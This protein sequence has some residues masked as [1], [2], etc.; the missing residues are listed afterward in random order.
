MSGGDFRNVHTIDDRCDSASIHGRH[1][2]R[3]ALEAEEENPDFAVL[4]ERGYLPEGR[5]ALPHVS[6]RGHEKESHYR[7]SCQ[8]SDDQKEGL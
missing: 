8:S 5:P 7:G 2:V 1:C 3:E 4:E 6:G